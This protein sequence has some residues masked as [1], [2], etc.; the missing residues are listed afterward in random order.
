LSSNLAFKAGLGIERL[1][2]AIFCV[3]N[4]NSRNQQA[5]RMCGFLRTRPTARSMREGLRG[6]SGR[7]L[8]ATPRGT[9]ARGQPYRNYC[10][11][12]KAGVRI[13]TPGKSTM[14]GKVMTGL[15]A[16]AI[17]SVATTMSASAQQKKVTVTIPKEVCEIVTV[18]TQNWGQ[19]TM[20]VCGPP[21]GPR[22]QATAISPK[23]KYRQAK[24]K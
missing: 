16:V 14:L 7:D 5:L 12:L 1:T 13:L 2:A 22:G 10:V 19:Q 9:A 4:C 21:G 11:L 8:R 24:P 23:L 6:H 15:A 17:V 18:G 20:E 3:D